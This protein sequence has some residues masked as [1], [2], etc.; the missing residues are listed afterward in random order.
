LPLVLETRLQ[1]AEFLRAER[2]V[3]HIVH[4]FQNGERALGL[5]LAQRFDQMS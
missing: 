4:V 1:F 2:F 3:I 5:L